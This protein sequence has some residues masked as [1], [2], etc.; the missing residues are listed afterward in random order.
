DIA[1]NHDPKAI[2]MHKANHPETKHFIENIW[3]VDPREACCGRPVGL[4]WFSPDCTHHSRA[5]GAK[6]RKKKIRGLAWVVIRWAKR[7]RPKVIILENVE[8]FKSWGRLLPDGTPDK[9]HAGE[10]FRK[11][12]SRL[13][14]LGYTVEF[15]SLVAADY[16]TP[17]T[18]KRLFL[19]A[20]TDNAPI[21]WPEPT[22]G[23]ARPEG[24]IPAA[25][26]IDWSLPCPS[27]FERPRPL[28]D[29]TMRRIAA[30]IRRYVIETGDPFII[31]VT[32]QGDSRVHG[33]D[34]PVRTI[35]AAHRG[36]LAFVAPTLIQTSYGERKG[37]R[38]RVPGLNKPLGTI[39]AGG[40][41]H[42]LVA[43]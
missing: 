14:D 39:V 30:G 10:T 26:I 38:P 12:V 32:H 5:K 22:H 6:P 20:R 9:Q 34:E 36:E 25:R 43:A 21:V 33:I 29:A 2:A 24:W 41:K 13:T 35:T 42:A 11:W 19:I 23:D 1:I 8:E 7:V 18:R 40:V 37:Q 27:I 4:A 15:R 28:A 16:G 3:K 17:T 31:P